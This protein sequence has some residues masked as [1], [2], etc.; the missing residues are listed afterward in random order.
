MV[1]TGS[2]IRTHTA[3]TATI[4]TRGS[5]QNA[6]VQ[7]PVQGPAPIAAGMHLTGTA[8]MAGPAAST[9]FAASGR[10]APIVALVDLQD[11]LRHRRRWGQDRLEVLRGHARLI[12]GYAESRTLPLRCAPF[13]ATAPAMVGSVAL[14]AARAR[15]RS[16]PAAWQ[17]PRAPH[18]MAATLQTGGRSM[19]SASWRRTRTATGRA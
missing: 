7:G 15:P 4:V 14:A 9:A 13:G 2:Q 17:S 1:G 6:R 19:P 16:R 11:R 3:T 18:T 12:G 5:R 8:T 10:T